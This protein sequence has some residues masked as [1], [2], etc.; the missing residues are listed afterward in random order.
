MCY[1]YIYL[2]PWK[3]GE[4]EYDQFKFEYEPF[5]VGMGSRSRDTSHL[6]EAQHKEGH[7]HTKIAR[8]HAI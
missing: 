1:V 3:P 7:E 4:Y 8:I 5:Y 2:D 6:R